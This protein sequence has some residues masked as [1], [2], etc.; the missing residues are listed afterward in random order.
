[1]FGDEEL[2]LSQALFIEFSSMHRFPTWSWVLRL[3][4]DLNTEQK[5]QQKNLI[6]VML[7]S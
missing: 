7:G 3:L 4:E 6:H 2:I 1:M 5:G